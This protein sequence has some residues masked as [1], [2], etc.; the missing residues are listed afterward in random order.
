MANLSIYQSNHCIHPP[1]G[2]LGR[3]DSMVEGVSRFSGIAVTAAM[4]FCSD[5]TVW[6]YSGAPDLTITRDGSG[7]ISKQRSFE[8]ELKE[9]N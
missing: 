9:A 4:V 8:K 1:V 5:I 3:P 2:L 7:I 6:I